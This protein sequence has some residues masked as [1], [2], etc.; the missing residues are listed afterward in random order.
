MVGYCFIQSWG[1]Y[2]LVNTLFG[3]LVFVYRFSRK[4]M[5]LA[6]LWFDVD[7]PTMATLLQ[8]LMQ[9]MSE[10]YEKGSIKMF[11]FLMLYHANNAM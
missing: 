10:L 2:V 8:P 4:N 11:N 3:L 6:G 5:I 1:I 9:E 7:K